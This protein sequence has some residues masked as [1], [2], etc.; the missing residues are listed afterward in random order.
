MHVTEIYTYPVKS[1]AGISHQSA[2][3]TV[4]GLR[5]DRQWMVV[6]PDGTFMTQRIYPQMALVETGISDSKLVLSSFGMEDWLVDDPFD[7]Q[8]D[9]IATDVWGSGINGVAHSTSTNQWLSD[10]IGTDC[11]LISFPETENRQ[12]DTEFASEGDHTLF[13]DG[14]PLLLAAQASLDDL[15]SKLAEPVGMNRFRPNIVVSGCDAFEEDS[16]HKIK[17]NQVGLRFAKHCERCSV[18]TVNQATGMLEGPEP[19]HT[20]SSYRRREDGEV[21]FGTCLV[22]EGTGVL[23]IGDEV[24]V[25]VPAPVPAKAG[26][27]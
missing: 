9:R 5:H 24:S 15:N 10:A 16:W 4:T 23:S 19:I 6:Q 8:A 18:P 14:Y 7:G 27:S 26:I 25:L 2:E 12:C 22:P 13:A 3:L 11:M 21:Y 20:L 1:L 17:I